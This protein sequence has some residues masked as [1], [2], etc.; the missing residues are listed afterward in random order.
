MP[1]LLPDLLPTHAT[2]LRSLG[3]SPHR[4]NR[5][6]ASLTDADC[7]TLPGGDP[8][9][10]LNTLAPISW[11]GHLLCGS[12]HEDLPGPVGRLV[13]PY[14]FLGRATDEHLAFLCEVVC[15]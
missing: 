6:L 2:R 14:L 11:Q 12:A 7:A 9:A 4:L 3:T 8:A 5:T 15:E 1:D 10:V 13:R